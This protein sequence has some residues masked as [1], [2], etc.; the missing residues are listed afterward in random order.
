MS[1]SNNDKRY[2]Y[3]WL[4]FAIAKVAAL[5]VLAIKFRLFSRNVSVPVKFTIIGIAVAVWLIFALY[6]NLIEWGKDMQEGFLKGV[7]AG[8][9]ELFLPISL[10]VSGL[11]AYLFIKDYM[12][13]TTTVLVSAALGLFF[14]AKHL[15][16]K[17]AVL[18]DRGYVNVFR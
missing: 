9:G 17:R 7:V 1:L 10:W 8:I 3:F 11:L 13:F 6:R 12:F 4:Y 14:R 5:V 16:Y 18:K 2:L 15:Q